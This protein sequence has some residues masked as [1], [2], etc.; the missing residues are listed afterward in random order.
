MRRGNPEVL[1]RG[2]WQQNQQLDLLLLF[3][4]S[5]VAHGSSQAMGQ[6]RAAAKAYATAKATLAPNH[7]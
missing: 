6:I 4:A 1:D 5:P 3:K 7:T 2:N